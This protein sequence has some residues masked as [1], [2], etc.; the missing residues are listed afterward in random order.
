M[1]DGARDFVS[2][3]PYAIQT[4]VDENV[5]IHHIFPVKWCTTNGIDR[6]RF[7]S[8]VNKTP[9]AAETNRMI[10]GHAPSKYLARV[11]TK[12][13]CDDVRIDEILATHVVDPATLR[14]DDFDSFFDAR[15]AQLLGRI[16]AA[17]GKQLL[18]EVDEQPDLAAD[19]ESDELAV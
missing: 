3:E 11:A 4:Y 15:R 6:G 13:A 12:A 1:R 16:S 17:M 18:E 8:I 2:G 9:L 7:D 14:A 10:G 5:D 19:D